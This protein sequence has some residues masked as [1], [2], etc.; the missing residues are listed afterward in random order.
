MPGARSARGRWTGVVLLP[1]VLAACGGG[2]GGRGAVVASG[3]SSSSAP[4][5]VIEGAEAR[6]ESV[7]RRRDVKPEGLP[8]AI[9]FGIPAR[10][11]CDHPPATLPTVVMPATVSLGELLEICVEGF[12]AGAEVAVQ[13][14]I[15]DGRTRQEAVEGGT[16]RRFLLHPLGPLEPVGLYVAMATSGAARALASTQVV[17]PD[18]VVV[19][20][21]A[22]QSA[23]AG[24]TFRFAVAFAP[25]RS[26]L[27]DLYG[28]GYITSLAAQTDDAGRA[29]LEIATQPGDPP[30]QYF[31]VPR[32]FDNRRPADFRVT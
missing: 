8:D 28:Q 6:A 19:E 10:V 17:L 5:P 27:L 31:L 16:R 4:P 26:V 15:P 14:S 18:R 3:R 30:R 7:L 29:V 25:R 21:L 9:G 24:T 22:P 20:T 1:L 11:A 2:E 13:L 32:P 23:P 12:P